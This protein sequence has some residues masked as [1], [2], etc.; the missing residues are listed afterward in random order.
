M[1]NLDIE[2]ASGT[3]AELAKRVFALVNDKTTDRADGVV[4]VDHKEYLDPELGRREREQIFGR[5]PI[6]PIH[7]SEIP[8]PGDYVTVPLPNN[9][10]LLVRQKTGSVRGFINSCRHRGARLVEDDAGCRKMFTCR[11]HGWTYAL[12]GALKLI[13]KEDTFGDINHADLGLVEIPCEERHGFVW[14]VDAPGAPMDLADWIGVEL[15]ETMSKYELDQYTCFRV[16]SFDEPINWKVLMDGFLDNYHIESLHVKT[17]ATYFHSN[18]QAYDRIGRH[19]RVLAPRTSIRKILDESPETAPIEKHV[20]VAYSFMPNMVLLRQPDHFQ[21]L[22]F[23]PDAHDVG[24][25]R[26]QIRLLIR[27]PA[28]SEEQIAF[29]EKNWKILIDVLHDEDM[30]LS[31]HLQHAMNNRNAAPILLGR[32]EL[33]NQVFHTWLEGA[34]ADPPNWDA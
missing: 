2:L 22:T 19:I 4:E 20:T 6:V 8:G 1:V 21:L 10:V 9:E 28:V 3:K 18:T 24:R 13:S 31:R 12:D 32:N 14:V 15:D 5:V 25:C 33:S 34:L 16:G 27:E 30:V 17:V 29:W 23:V 11:Y 26:F 7:G